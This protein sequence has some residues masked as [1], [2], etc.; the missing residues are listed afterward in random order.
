MAEP[1]RVIQTAQ[2]AQANIDALFSF[3]TPPQTPAK[4]STA[5]LSLMSPSAPESGDKLCELPI[6]LLVDFPKEKHP[7]RPY[8][9][10]ELESLREDIRLHGILQPLL[11]RPHPTM[12]GHYEM[13][14]GH[15]RAAAARELGYTTLPCVVRQLDDDDALLQMI[16]S[17]LCQRERLL[18]SEKAWAYRY[19]LEAMRRQG[20]RSDL[21]CAQ[22]GEKLES[23]DDL[24]SPQRAAKS[25]S[26]DDLTS[27]HDGEKLEALNHQGGATSTQVVS[28]LRSNEML[29]EQVGE[30]RE[31][32]RR[33]I[34]LTYLLPSLLDK[35]DERKLPLTA[36]ENLSFL[37]ADGQRIVENFFFLQRLLPITQPMSQRLREMDGQGALN[38]QALE[39]AFLSPPVIGKM[40][41]VSIRLKKWKKYFADTATQK[42]VVDTI[43]T[44]LKEYFEKRKGDAE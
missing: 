33:Y 15:N 21:T 10:Q 30:S 36:G 13:I 35:V 3:D 26:D 34:R 22:D 31:T 1:E 2:Q 44:A 19:E 18:P 4:E 11:V 28:K 37:S 20:Y 38:E 29:G 5:S 40:A 42:E 12:P 39:A 16:S 25:R 24:T 17:N 6:G 27:R 8:T 43:E 7:F 9:A 41:T 23:A 14:A 32:I